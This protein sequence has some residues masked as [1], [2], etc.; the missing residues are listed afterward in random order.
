MLLSIAHQ[1][2]AHKETYSSSAENSDNEGDDSSGSGVEDATAATRTRRNQKTSHRHRLDDSASE[3]DN[4]SDGAGK[5][6]DNC[7][8]TLAVPTAKTDSCAIIVTE[9]VAD[10][11]ARDVIKHMLS[12]FQM[13]SK[14]PELL[15]SI[16]CIICPNLSD[17][18]DYVF[19]CAGQLCSSLF[20]L[21]AETET[22]SDS[23]D[24]TTTTTVFATTSSS[25]NRK[26]NGASPSSRSSS[27]TGHPTEAEASKEESKAFLIDNFS[28][29]RIS[30][31]LEVV[32]KILNQCTKECASLLKSAL[33]LRKVT[34]FVARTNRLE[35][36]SRVVNT[37]DEWEEEDEESEE[38]ARREAN[39][40][41]SAEER[42]DTPDA[43]D[44]QLERLHA[45]KLSQQSTPSIS[46]LF[47]LLSNVPTA[48]VANLQTWLIQRIKSCPKRPSKACVAIIK[49]TQQTC[50]V[51][52]ALWSQMFAIVK[53]TD[54]KYHVEVSFRFLILT[55]KSRSIP[56]PP[57]QPL[58]LIFAFII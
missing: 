58:R 53:E 33:L 31:L 4:D 2:F 15:T 56:P 24:I 11:V 37:F 17:P 42:K 49:R 16:A 48:H 8:E 23:E 13:I 50:S 20:A 44:I 5:G 27:K 18:Q 19:L 21:F 55:F 10:L 45:G 29:A 26:R 54:K 7:A 41:G 52:D 35:Q 51:L 39:N 46:M 22:V 28:E 34:N 6:E 32:I 40:T 3:S 38:G 43:V 12:T 9:N 36:A 25:K 1:R 57:P 14:Q 30:Q 47:G